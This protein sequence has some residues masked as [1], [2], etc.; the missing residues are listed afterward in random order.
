MPVPFFDAGTNTNTCSL[1]HS[2][3]W[4]SV[5]SHGK[6][7]LYDVAVYAVTTVSYKTLCQELFFSVKVTRFLL[8]DHVVVANLW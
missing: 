5:A 6:N 3:Y 4:A 1:C 7:V 2:V 8:L